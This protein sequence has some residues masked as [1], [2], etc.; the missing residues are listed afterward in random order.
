[1]VFDQTGGGTSLFAWHELEKKALLEGCHTANRTP[2]DGEK[3]SA[4]SGL[5]GS[6]EQSAADGRFEPNVTDAPCCVDVGFPEKLPFDL[7]LS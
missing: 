5:K 2:I 4:V 3:P 1:L 6:L 7:N